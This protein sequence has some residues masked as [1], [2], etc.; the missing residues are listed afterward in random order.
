VVGREDT[1][2]RKDNGEQQRGIGVVQTSIGVGSL[3]PG[4]LERIAEILV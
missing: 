2:H 1:R 3:H 4:N